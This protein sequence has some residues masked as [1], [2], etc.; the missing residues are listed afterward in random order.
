VR[1]LGIESSCDETAAAV[2]E[3]G[4]RTLSSVVATQHELHGRFGGIVPEVACRA[5]AETMLPVVAQ[6][7][8]EA[9][10]ALNG[11]DGVA[12]TTTPGLIGALLVGVTTAKALSWSLGLPLL[13]VNHLHAHAYSVWLAGEEPSLPAV[14]LVVSGGHTSLFL[15][16]G[17]L[18]HR[19]LG[20]T[21]DD[22]AGE[23]F[24]KVAH[25]LRLG[26]PGGPAVEEAARGG[27]PAAVDFPRSGLG[28]PDACF[29]FSGLKTAVLYHCLGQNASRGDIESASYEPGFVADVA[30]SFQGAVVDVLATKTFGAAE[31]HMAAGVIVGGGVAANGRLRERLR[32][33]A[34]ERGFVLRLAPRRLCT[35]NAAMT[36]G[37]GCRML[38]AGDVAALDV[39]AMP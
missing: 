33:E 11:L 5:H 35:D 10:V 19:L 4:V 17:P 38:E 24:D 23:A 18:Q 26:Y 7:L 31:R 25:I 6:A 3:D 1:V 28:E 8:A 36:A 21:V 30:A 12:V 39:Q 34:D 9:G 16:E 14:S 13:A 32:R 20:G 2:V 37:I 27:D 22:A 15:T 29:S